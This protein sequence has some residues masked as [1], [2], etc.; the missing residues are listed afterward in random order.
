MI[1][2]LVSGIEQFSQTYCKDPNSEYNNTVA[3][4]QEPK[5]L[6]IG[7]SDS[8]VDPGVLMGAE[9][10]EIF[11]HRNI[12]GLVPPCQSDDFEHYHGTSAVLEH[13]VVNLQVEHIIV[14]GHANCG[15]I[16]KLMKGSSRKK[17][18]EDFID[19]WMTMIESVKEDVLENHP[20]ASPKEQAHLCEKGAVV[21]SLKDLITF[22]WIKE[23]VDRG[24]L[25]L[26]G[27]HFN[28]GILSTYDEEDQA[29]ETKDLR[30]R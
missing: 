27:W 13:A 6:V 11:V 10:G 21:Q 5:V 24:E 3:S 26:H 8:M 29:F 18:G 16:A 15:G 23:K 12:A 25:K 4:G 9:P 22:P 19:K 2:K 17:K 30:N 20:N 7:C 28:K 14:L 1:S